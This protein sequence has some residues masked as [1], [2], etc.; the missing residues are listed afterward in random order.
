M[1]THWKSKLG[2]PNKHIYSGS[3]GK[4]LSQMFGCERNF[5]FARN[6]AEF[7]HKMSTEVSVEQPE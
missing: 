1:L 5:P 3:L 7:L 2:S 4:R 6:L